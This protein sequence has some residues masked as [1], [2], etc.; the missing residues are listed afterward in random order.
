M[1]V[2]HA[3]KR[4]QFGK[5]IGEYQ[6]IQGMLAD[7]FTEITA[8]RSLLYEIAGRRDQGMHIETET[9]AIKLFASEMLDRAADKALQ[10]HGTVG[11]LK[12]CPVE[13]IYREARVMRL[14]QGTS[15]IL[16]QSIARDLLRD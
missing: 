3:K 16:R 14:L 6:L 13:R 8:T 10:I 15:E 11:Y 2:K 4:A 5:P 12:G 9:A 7:M 1:S